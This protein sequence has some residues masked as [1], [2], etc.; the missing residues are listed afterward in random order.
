VLADLE[1]LLTSRL[2]ADALR[3]DD[4]GF[5]DDPP[6]KIS[7]MTDWSVQTNLGSVRYLT[8]AVTPDRR[9]P[10]L[11]AEVQKQLRLVVDLYVRTARS[12][13]FHRPTGEYTK[14]GINGEIARHTWLLHAAERVFGANATLAVEMDHVVHHLL[15]RN[16]YSRSFVTKVGHKPPAQPHHRPSTNYLDPWPGLLIGGPNP[17]W[18]DLWVDFFSNEIAINW[19]AGLV[20][21]LARNYTACD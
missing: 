1:E 14:W 16:K 21:A 13:S 20:Y 4:G 2:T 15:G 7:D 12:S 17:Y 8:S 5:N 10:D 19:Q 18:I 6:C 3:C 11:V 9:D